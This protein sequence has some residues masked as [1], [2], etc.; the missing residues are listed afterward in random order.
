MPRP[1]ASALVLAALVADGANHTRHRRLMGPAPA[2]LGPPPVVRDWPVSRPSAVDKCAATKGG[3]SESALV[4]AHEHALKMAT[5]ITDVGSAE[6]AGAYL[7]LLADER[8]PALSRERADAD[9]DGGYDDGGEPMPITTFVGQVARVCGQ[10]KARWQFC[11]NPVSRSK[12]ARPGGASKSGG[13]EFAQYPRDDSIARLAG[14]GFFSCEYRRF[15]ARL[16]CAFVDPGPTNK[17]GKVG[18]TGLV[19]TRDN[20]FP[21]HGVT[22][23]ANAKRPGGARPASGA[24]GKAR[25]LVKYKALAHHLAVYPTAFGH[26][27]NQLPRL[28]FLLEVLPPDV[29]ILVAKTPL[30]N[31][32]L[33]LLDEHMTYSPHPN[34][35][36]RVVNYK[37]GATYFA[38]TLYFAGEM[39]RNRPFWGERLP[40]NSLSI[41]H[42]SWALS[43]PRRLLHQRLARPMLGDRAIYGDA[44]D[45]RRRR[46][47]VLVIDRSD[48]SRRML[49]N[50][51]AVMAALRRR[52][53]A[54]EFVEFRGSQL[55]LREQIGAF[56]RADVVLGPHGAALGLVGFMKAGGT[57][58]EV[59][60][61]KREWPAVFM[62][63]AL[64]A[65]QRYALSFALTGGHFSALE[66]NETDVKVLFDDVMAYHESDARG[67]AQLC[68]A[69]DGSCGEFA[70]PAPPYK[71]RCSTKK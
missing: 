59:A 48:A 46:A 4:A 19:Y 16:P 58:I 44:R 54:A 12:G 63:V 60:Y 36:T 55:P 61:R 47:V 30:L 24:P 66:A 70:T 21:V 7:K 52:A 22:S 45:A 69:G 50:H 28:L 64:G 5:E 29:P 27:F 15:V 13:G 62:P 8:A 57:V 11:P 14:A 68:V 43:V 18:P 38:Q 31:Q 37:P 41:E 35:S 17:K 33:A 56:A 51:C 49:K 3:D 65:G 34:V 10:L 1:V 53:P 23:D 25:P 42:C 20:V 40:W 67:D 9:A 6:A 2:R 71:T 26:I 32:L 39:G